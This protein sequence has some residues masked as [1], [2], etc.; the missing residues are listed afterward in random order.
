MSTTLKII[1]AVLITLSLPGI[2]MT[3]FAGAVTA[4][5]LWS[6]F[7][8]DPSDIAHGMAMLELVPMIVW[9]IVGL[10]YLLLLWLLWFA[11]KKLLRSDHQHI[12]TP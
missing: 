7:F 9:T 5:L 11:A 2:L 12:K 6:E 3:L 10:V 4:R 1:R 8:P